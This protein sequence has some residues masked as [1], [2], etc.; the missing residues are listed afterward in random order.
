MSRRRA[1]KTRPFVKLDFK[2]VRHIMPIVGPEGLAV[3]TCLKMHE[4]RRTGQCNP[5]YQ[6]IADET[7]MSRRSAIRYTRILVNLKAVSLVPIWTDK[8]DRTS[9]Q[10]NLTDPARFDYGQTQAPGVPDPGGDTTA[11]PPPQSVPQAHYG[12]D[13]Q[14]LDPAPLNQFNATMVEDTEKS[15][16]YKQRT[17]TH[18]TNLVRHLD[19]DINICDQ[20]FGLLDD[21]GRLVEGPASN[22][23]DEV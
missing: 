22:D 13:S 10:Y 20:C 1:N 19:T 11:P 21:S 15:S 18:P 14:A 9:N 3:Y 6:T 12:G 23:N 5:A 16:T 2:L 17:C 7:G 4:N 8:G